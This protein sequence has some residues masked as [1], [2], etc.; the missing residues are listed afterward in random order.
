VA[1]P[2][3]FFEVL[4][5]DG[6]RLRSFYSTVFGWE[7]AE[8]EEMNGHRFAYVTPAF[9]DVEVRGGIGFA[10]PGE[11]GRVN[12][13]IEVD[14]LDSTLDAVEANG[15]RRVIEPVGVDGYHFATFED[16]E[17]NTVGIVLPFPDR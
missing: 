12:F 10:P 14:D 1:R 17:L 2:V 5:K 16:P 9:D 11:A 8:G 3:V 15:G 7:Y 4:A 6:D 13:Y